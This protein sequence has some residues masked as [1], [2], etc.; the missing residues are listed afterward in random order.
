MWRH[1]IRTALAAPPSFAEMTAEGLRG[2]YLRILGFDGTPAALGEAI[3]RRADALVYPLHVL[4]DGGGA[5]EAD[6]GNVWVR[7]HRIHHFA[8]A[9][10]DIQDACR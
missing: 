9:V 8:S 1:K 4:R 5:D 10:D 7:A 3:G 2:R 6:G